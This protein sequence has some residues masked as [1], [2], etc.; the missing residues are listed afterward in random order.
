MYQYPIN[1]AAQFNES[2]CPFI[3]IPSRFVALLQTFTSEKGNNTQ[4]KSYYYEN[5]NRNYRKKRGAVAEQLAKLLAD[6]NAS[7]HQNKKCP[8]ECNRR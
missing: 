3:E 7:L 5:K 8:L 4:L 1:F 6:R 2:F